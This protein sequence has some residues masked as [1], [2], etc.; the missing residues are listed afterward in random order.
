MEVRQLQ[1]VLALAEECHFQ[2]A[3]SRLS[4][5][6][7]SLSQHIQRVEREVGVELFVRST[8]SVSLT[9]AGEVLVAR[10]REILAGLD[11][12][13]EATRE[14]GEGVTGRLS[15]GIAG[16]ATYSLVPRLV[17]GF[18]HEHPRLVIH[19]SP[20]MM[21]SQQVPALV[22]GRL[23]IGFLRPPVAVDGWSVEVVDSEPMVALLPAGHPGAAASSVRLTDLQR[24]PF[25]TFSSRSD[26]RANQVVF[27]ACRKAGFDPRIGQEVGMVA[28][29][30][31]LVSAGIGVAVVPHSIQCVKVDGAVYR[32]ID[33]GPSLD[34]AMCWR[35]EMSPAV[36]RFVRYVQ[37][38]IAAPLA[39]QVRRAI[40]THDARRLSSSSGHSR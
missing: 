31:G 39:D 8:R 27:S 7:P 6:Q 16:S 23:D 32:P 17:R 15:I 37:K 29:V 4:V 25:I 12:A 35:E 21:T 14:R 19:L 36:A 34:L 9:P 26:S 18:R 20:E 33:D 3:A 11:D 5:S 1:Y 13:I 2:R 22:D 30:V 10:A 28:A 38:S 40:E 24:D